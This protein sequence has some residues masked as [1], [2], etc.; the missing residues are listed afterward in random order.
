MS[1]PEDNSLK[2]GNFSLNDYIKQTYGSMSPSGGGDETSRLVDDDDHTFTTR[3][4]DQDDNGSGG[5]TLR[6]MALELSL[7]LNLLITFT[8]LVAYIR[9]MSLSVLAAL[10]GLLGWAADS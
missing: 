3:S 1:L 2:D 8:K 10:P 4:S 5:W 6:R 9:T 7:Y